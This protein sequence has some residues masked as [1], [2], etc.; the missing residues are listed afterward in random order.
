M[1]KKGLLRFN[2]KFNMMKENYLYKRDY[3]AE[4]KNIL[5]QARQRAYAA[6]NSAMVEAYWQIGRR[7]VEE[8][9]NGENRAKYGKEVLQ[10]L[11]AE[12]TNEFGKGYS[13]RTLREIRQFYLTF[14]EIEK[15]RTLFAKLSWS[16]FQRVL[17]V[18]NEK[19]PPE[20]ELIRE[21]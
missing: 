11:S 14:P 15:W 19:A 3:I 8:E 1:K 21:I 18:S 13:Y 2:V 6:I 9:Q 16:H 20:E 4:I 17:K 7:I 10:N 12:L 5:S